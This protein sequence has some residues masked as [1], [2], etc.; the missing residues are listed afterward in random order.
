MALLAVAIPITPGKEERWRRFVDELNASR[1]A[2]FDASRRRMGVRE[3]TLHQVTPNGEL[4]IV[5]LEGDDPM[6]AFAA[7]GAAQDEFTDWFVAEVA[8][9]HDF[10]L[11]RP[12]P[13]PPPELIADS[14]SVEEAS[15][16]VVLRFFDEILGKKNM[17][18][19]DEVIADDYK[20]YFPGAPSPL[21]K[22]DMSGALSM[23]FTAF[24]DMAVEVKS[25]IAEGDRVAVIG[26]ITATHQ[27]EFQGV[28]PTGK[29]IAVRN[30]SQYRVRDGKLVEDYPGFNPMDI[31]EQIGAAS[32][33]AH[34]G[35]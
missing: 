2:E 10:D 6:A 13:G 1:K 7:F 22:A 29:R 18:A 28:P 16:A 25:I 30:L 33:A 5:T 8:A 20:N 11:R 35:A 23:F 34:A 27:G 31:M 19:I 3:R 32:I 14:G 4:V 24:P 26:E 15:K 17:A 9:V 21:G 12:P